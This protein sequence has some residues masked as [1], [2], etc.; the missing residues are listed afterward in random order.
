MA[1]GLLN[2]QILLGLVAVGLILAAYY[3]SYGGDSKENFTCS[4]I[5]ENAKNYTF[6][7]KG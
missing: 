4:Q 7:P 5:A 1:K 3:F 6:A 2:N